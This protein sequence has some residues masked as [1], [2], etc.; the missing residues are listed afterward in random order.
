MANKESKDK[1]AVKTQLQINNVYT[2]NMEFHPLDTPMVLGLV[3]ADNK[4]ETKI[5]L[6]LNASA[7]KDN[8]YEVTLT[9]TASVNLEKKEIFKADVEQ[10]GLFTLDGFDE[11]ELSQALGTYC[12][13]ILFP[14]ARE[15]MSTL[16]EHG[17]FPQIPLQPINFGEVYKR[18]EQELKAKGITTPPML[19]GNPDTINR[20]SH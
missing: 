12:P 7:F 5:N 10:A 8:Q 6:K 4:P 3:T 15:A 18:Y 9:I 20:M 14:Y 17:G 16:V 2:K 13:S 19:Y 1:K 11:I